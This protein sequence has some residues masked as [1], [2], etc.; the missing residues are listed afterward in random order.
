M[1]IVDSSRHD[2]TAATMA[3]P[4]YAKNKFKVSLKRDQNVNF[5]LSLEAHWAKSYIQVLKF[6]KYAILK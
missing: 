6:N 5:D 1:L 3:R 2:I 4:Y